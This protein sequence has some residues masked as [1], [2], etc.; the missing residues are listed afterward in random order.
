MMNNNLC[1]ASD[2]QFVFITSVILSELNSDII[3]CGKHLLEHI[4]THHIRNTVSNKIFLSLK[5]SFLLKDFFRFRNIYLV[6][7]STS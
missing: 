5:K 2:D 4:L 6:S 3:P 7:K 1:L